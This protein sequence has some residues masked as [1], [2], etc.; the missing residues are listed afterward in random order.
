M[1]ILGVKVVRAPQSVGSEI[2]SRGYFQDKLAVF[3]LYLETE[4]WVSG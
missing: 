3:Q 1:G 4:E 2:E